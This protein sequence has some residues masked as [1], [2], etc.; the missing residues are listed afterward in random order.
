[1]TGAPRRAAPPPAAEPIVT[2]WWRTVD[3]WLLGA[4]L[5]LV[6]IGLVLGLAASPPLALDNGKP[7]FHYVK[8]QAV[9]TTVSLCVMVAVS[10]L[11][12]AAVRRLGVIGFGCG[13]IALGLLPVM[14]TDF[15]KGAV[16]WY[17]LGFASLQPSEFM[18][19][20]FAIFAGW[21]MAGS[22]ERGGPP[23]KLLSFFAA[24]LVAGL[25]VIQPDFGQATLVLAIWGVMYF[26]AGASMP[27]IG[28]LAGA[29]GAAG[30]TAYQSSEHFARRIDGFLNSEV[31]PR[32]QLGYATQAIVEGGFFGVGV[33]EGSVKNTLPDAH[34]DFIIA[35]AAEEYGLALVL[36]VI[37]LFLLITLRALSRLAN[38]R[39]AFARLA[40]AGLAAL[41]GL[42]AFV[43][44]GVAVRIL[45]AKGM[46]LPFISYGGSSMLAAGIAMGALLAVTRRRPQTDVTEAFG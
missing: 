38:E 20:C 8:L 40:G 39:D 22:L 15:G 32:T 19:P 1:M 36:L 44:L 17:S 18:K 4:V 24:C 28:I 41:F 34:T 13:L 7:E 14:G 9:F 3:K 26:V 10:M 6:V 16:R 11:P 42:Q 2:R 43:N 12:L 37:G 29:V 21:L 30:F 31:D 25:L 35:V 5:A 23:G 27:L 46:T 33:G 45:P